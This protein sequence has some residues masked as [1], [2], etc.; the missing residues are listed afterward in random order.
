MP[1]DAIAE[2]KRRIATTRWPTR[3]LVADRSQGVQLAT[4]QELA[5]CC[6]EDGLGPL[7]VAQAAG[8]RRARPA[9]H[10]PSLAGIASAP[11]SPAGRVAAPFRMGA[12]RAQRLP[13]RMI[14][15]A[16]YSVL[17]MPLS[18]FVCSSSSTG[19]LNAT[20]CLPWSGQAPLAITTS[21]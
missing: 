3:E 17:N 9:R 15:K 5:R 4:I 11:R 20:L 10:P 19:D 2:L 7:L 16:P 14:F 8:N 1:D 18:R 21:L 6:A 13:Q 12:P